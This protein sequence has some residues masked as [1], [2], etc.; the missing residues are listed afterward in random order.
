[1][2]HDERETGIQAIIFLQAFAGIEE[3]REKAERGWDG[4]SQEHKQK[5][6][7]MYALLKAAPIPGMLA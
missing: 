4:M 5:T 2:T 3:P 7:H 6:L 1:V